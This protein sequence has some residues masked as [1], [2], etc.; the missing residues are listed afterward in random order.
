M[1]LDQVTVASEGFTTRLKDIV[2]SSDDEAGEDTPV[3]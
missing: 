1:E 3:M 2:E